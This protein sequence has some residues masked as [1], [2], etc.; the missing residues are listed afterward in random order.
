MANSKVE[1][2]KGS[3]AE[4]K[5]RFLR[6]VHLGIGAVALAGAVIFPQLKVLSVF[7]GYEGLNAAAHEGLRRAVKPR[8]NRLA[9]S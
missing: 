2:A 9:T 8:P 6:D 3:G 5:L 7:A 1:G 4:R